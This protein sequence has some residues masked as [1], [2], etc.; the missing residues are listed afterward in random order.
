M[1][2]EL[3]P[4]MLLDRL[5]VDEWLVHFRHPVAKRLL[6]A[7]RKQYQA[8]AIR[9]IDFTL[10]FGEWLYVWVESGKLNRRGCRRGQYVMARHKDRGAYR[11]GNVRIITNAENLREAH[12]GAQHTAV[13]RQR[14]SRAAVR[15]WEEHRVRA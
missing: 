14:M 1:A 9:K 15:S 3:D 2:S 10:S 6:L 7:Y 12:L 4:K 8:A 13:A 5:T 11:L